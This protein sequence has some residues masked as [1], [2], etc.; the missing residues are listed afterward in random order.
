M[1]TFRRYGAQ[2]FTVSFMLLLTEEGCK[3]GNTLP[4]VLRDAVFP[5]LPGL[6][7]DFEFL[8]LQDDP[9]FPIQAHQLVPGGNLHGE[10]LEE[11]GNKEE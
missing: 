1:T 7:L 8:W 5:R 9:K 4:S 2:R 3:R 11:G 6:E 10:V